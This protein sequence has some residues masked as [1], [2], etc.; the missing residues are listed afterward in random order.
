MSLVAQHH[1][2][3][4][5]PLFVVNEGRELSLSAIEVVTTL[6]FDPAGLLNA[7]AN[8]DTCLLESLKKAV[9]LVEVLLLIENSPAFSS[10]SLRSRD[11]D[12]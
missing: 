5:R 11:L 10:E 1:K 12:R 3:N 7:Q 2:D 6:D 8:L 9:C 4:G